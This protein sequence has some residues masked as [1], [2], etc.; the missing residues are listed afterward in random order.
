MQATHT[1]AVDV[2]NLTVTFSNGAF[3]N[4]TVA[5][6]VTNYTN[7]TGVV[8]FNDVTLAYSTGSFLES[9]ALD[10]SLGNTVTITL[11]GDTFTSASGTMTSGVDFTP[12]NVPAGLT[13]VVTRTSTT[14]ATLELTGA[15]TAHANAQD[16]ANLGIAFTDSAFT[17]TPA[18]NIANSTKADFVV[19]F[20]DAAITYGGTGFTENGAN[21]GSLTG[22]ITATLAGDTWNVALSATDVTL[23]NVP[24]GLTPVLTRTSATVATLTFT[25]TATTHTNAVD[26]SDITFV[27]NDTAFAT[28]TAA[29]TAGATGPASSGRG[30]DF[31][32]SALT[33]GTTTFAEVVANNGSTTTTSS[34][35]L[36]GG[37]FVLA[38]GNFTQGV[39][40][41]V[42]NLPAGMTMVIT[43]NS[44]T[45]ATVSITGNATAHATA[46][47][48]ANLTITWLDGAFTGGVPLSS[49]YYQ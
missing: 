40:Y 47:D 24:A 38:L 4:T 43:A 39:H 34:V 11:A 18:A 8:D 29:V 41:N 32:D 10:G 1:N 45:T 14:T 49:K 36:T 46:D 7:N 12:S 16:I 3:T 31:F 20:G 19:D 9:S 2:A 37:T 35:T 48:V 5:S 22:S 26:V 17:A 33:Y 28:V 27:F 23:G 6:N 25:G 30:V 15:A 42:T 21:D 13:M 44:T